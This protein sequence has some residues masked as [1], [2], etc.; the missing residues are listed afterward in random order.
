MFGPHQI[1]AFEMRFT[2]EQCG[3][4]I[5]AF[6]AELQRAYDDELA[7]LARRRVE[8]QYRRERW[9]ADYQQWKTLVANQTDQHQETR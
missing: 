9:E 1:K 5:A 2:F 8:E 3:K 6:V 4:A 7:V